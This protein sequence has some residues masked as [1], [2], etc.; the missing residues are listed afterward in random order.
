MASAYIALEQERKH[1]RLSHG[2][3]AQHHLPMWWN[4]GQGRTGPVPGTMTR[5]SKGNRHAEITLMQHAEYLLHVCTEWE[6]GGKKILPLTHLGFSSW[7][8][9][10]QTGKRQISKRN[11]E[12][13]IHRCVRHVYIGRSVM[14]NPKLWLEL[15][16]IFHLRLNK[17]VWA[18]GWQR[19]I[20]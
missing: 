14:S 10:N 7:G 15:G 12:K 13:F 2:R 20:M 19:Q 6:W 9:I 5:L 16:S 18:S 8:P 17:G 1:W 4:T 3:G 11:K